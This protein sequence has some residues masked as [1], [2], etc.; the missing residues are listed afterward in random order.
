[1]KNHYM[2]LYLRYVR[3]CRLIHP[4]SNDREVINF[5]KRRYVIWEDTLEDEDWQRT[6]EEW[7]RVRCCIVHGESVIKSELMSAYRSLNRFMNE[8]DAR[9]TTLS[10]LDEELRAV[11]VRDGFGVDMLT[12]RQMYSI[13]QMI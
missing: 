4:K 9:L 8:V 7:Y 11:Y 6:I 12:N 3:W 1:M 5:M 13:A 2:D 10:Q